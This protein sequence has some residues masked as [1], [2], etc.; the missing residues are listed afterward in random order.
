[1]AKQEQGEQAFPVPS[2]EQF[3]KLVRSVKSNE[4]DKNEAAGAIG[5]AVNKAIEKNHLDKKAFAIFRQLD[6]LSDMKLSTT[7]SHLE[8]Y[9][10][11]GGL[12][13]RCEQQGEL[14]DREAELAAASVEGVKPRRAGRKPNGKA[15]QKV[16]GAPFDHQQD[17]EAAAEFESIGEVVPIHEVTH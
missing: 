8:H 1:M 5:Q 10:E 6:R 2:E 4:S 14:I 11:I 15:S 17:R 3:K 9:C 13:A 7:L 16:E 12:N